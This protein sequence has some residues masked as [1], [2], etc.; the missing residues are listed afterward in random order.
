MGSHP[1]TLCL[2]DSFL[3][4][5]GVDHE[6][7]FVGRLQHD[8]V[9]DMDYV[10]AGVPGYGPVQYRRV[11]EYRLQ[12]GPPPDRLLIATFLGNDFQDCVWNKDLPVTDGILGKRASWT[13]AV[14]QHSHLYRLATR[15]YH[16]LATH[17]TGDQRPGNGEGDQAWEGDFPAAGRAHLSGRVRANCRTLSSAEHR[18]LGR[19]SAQPRGGGMAAKVWRRG[20]LSTS[21]KLVAGPGRF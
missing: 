5:H 4:G 7:S 13:D 16:Q 2:G 9:G 11:L 17:D 3:F 1:W 12:Q 6:Q 15:V 10:N 14:K 20:L 21:R 8:H 19:D 18:S